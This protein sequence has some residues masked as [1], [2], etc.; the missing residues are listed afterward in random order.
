[1]VLQGA[2]PAKVELD[3]IQGISPADI[4]TF[5]SRGLRQKQPRLTPKVVH[6]SNMASLDEPPRPPTTMM[7]RNVPSVY[8]QATLAQEIDS[9]GFTGTYD[10]L[11]LPN[12]RV[13]KGS[14]GYAFVNFER[15]EDAVRFRFVLTGHRFRLAPG[16]GRKTG[17]V[18]MARRQGPRQNLCNRTDNADPS[19]VTG[20]NRRCNGPED[21]A[22]IDDP[23]FVIENP[24][25]ATTNTVA[26]AIVPAAET[27][28]T[29][30]RSSSR[31][32]T[33]SSCAEKR[34]PRTAQ[35][36]V[37]TT[38]GSCGA[39]NDRQKKQRDLGELMLDLKK[40]LGDGPAFGGFATPYAPYGMDGTLT[41]AATAVTCKP[42]SEQTTF[43]GRSAA[44][45]VEEL[46]ALKRRLAA[47][48]SETTPLSNGG[49]HHIGQRFLPGSED[50]GCF[51]LSRQCGGEPCFLR[52]AFAWA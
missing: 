25:A 45:D 51:R 20:D 7:L 38:L 44:A 33:G 5:T 14:I 50:D 13:M 35:P 17:E 49:T 10:Y 42:Q 9:L 39:S 18:C 43:Q 19:A 8:T 32:S 40:A 52:A 46:Q 41:S 12:D 30:A 4:L 1:M 15:P 16:R 23:S 47:R 48:L 22:F 28:S 27:P 26:D 34:W 11:F 36:A 29:S 6:A 21:P 24:V 37:P 2:E 3:T 31:G